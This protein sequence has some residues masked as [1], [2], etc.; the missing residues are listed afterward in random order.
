MVAREGE[1]FSSAISIKPI[2]LQRKKRDERRLIGK[3]K[4]HGKGIREGGG[5]S[6]GNMTKIH[7]SHA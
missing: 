7:Y 5:R 3:E 6:G 2:E 4:G 1:T